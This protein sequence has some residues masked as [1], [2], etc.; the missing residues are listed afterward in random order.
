MNNK[1]KSLAKAQGKIPK[2]DASHLETHFA[3]LL[4]ALGL[5]HRFTR[6]LRFCAS[7]NFKADFADVKNR[8]IVELEGGVWK[9]GGGGHNRGK[10][11]KSN[12]EKYNIAATLGY[13]V[14]RYTDVEAMRKFEQ[15]YKSILQVK[16]SEGLSK[17][18]PANNPAKEKPL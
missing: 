7:R 1:L 5:E 13:S 2:Q 9:R 14:L 12:C 11:Y 17:P 15:D 3:L 6:E 8:I 18:N 4:R 16:Q 10:G